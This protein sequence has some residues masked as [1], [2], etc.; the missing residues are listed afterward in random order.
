MPVADMSF[1][2]IVPISLSVLTLVVMVILHRFRS[3]DTASEKVAELESKVGGEVLGP[4][5]SPNQNEFT[6]EVVDESFE[7]YEYEG[8]M[9]RYLLKPLIG[10]RGETQVRID[11]HGDVFVE[12]AV[13]IKQIATDDRFSNRI[14]DIEL[15]DSRI[16]LALNSAAVSEVRKTLVGLPELVSP[17]R[18]ESVPEEAVKA[19]DH[20]VLGVRAAGGVSRA[21]VIDIAF[22]NK[23][24]WRLLTVFC[25]NFI[26]N[27][28]DRMNR[29][30]VWVR[31]RP[32][33]KTSKVTLRFRHPSN[34]S[35]VYRLG[36]LETVAFC[37]PYSA[38]PD[39]SQRLLDVLY[40]GYG[41]RRDF[42]ESDGEPSTVSKDGTE[43]L[44]VSLARDEEMC[45]DYHSPVGI[46]ELGVAE[47]ARRGWN[48]VP[49]REEVLIPVSG[50]EA[51]ELQDVSLH[52]S[53]IE[54]VTRASHGDGIWAEAITAVRGSSVR[55][56]YRG[57]DGTWYFAVEWL[58]DCSVNLVESDRVEPEQPIET[59]GDVLWHR[60]H[61]G[62]KRAYHTEESDGTAG[63]YLP[64][65]ANL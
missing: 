53:K 54:G 44:K 33:R 25:K 21:I 14:A 46:L 28:I 20:K 38:T 34:D 11:V 40:M 31:R 18:E 13:L 64:D 47:K 7:V 24:V 62:R 55:C 10:F 57:G 50:A 3:A 36:P 15:E 58:A 45:D 27:T 9:Y 61:S 2:Q 43:F 5:T 37:N 29:T 4:T 1:S 22:P 39:G 59:E 6:L 19:A 32:R 52:P 56:Y 12:E 60:L 35:E 17:E 42:L 63:Y 26:L 65:E 51:D 41:I 23:H 30:S 16:T 48:T 8:A 49:E